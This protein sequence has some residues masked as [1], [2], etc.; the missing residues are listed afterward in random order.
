MSQKKTY[1]Y[2][3]IYDFESYQQPVHKAAPSY[4]LNYESTHIPVSVF[5]ILGRECTHVCE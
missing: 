5:D 1:L 2:M 4:M 3:I